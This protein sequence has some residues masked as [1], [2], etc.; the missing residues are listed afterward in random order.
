VERAEE[1]ATPSGADA[2]YVDPLPRS[3]RGRGWRR[4]IA[5][6]RRTTGVGDQRPAQAGGG[7][8]AEVWESV[9]ALPGRLDGASLPNGVVELLV[10]ER[11]TTRRQLLDINDRCVTAIE[12]GSAV[13]WAIVSGSPAAWAAALGPLAETGGLQ[14]TGDEPLARRLLAAA[15][16]SPR[17]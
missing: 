1:A 11:E 16:E 10:E 7:P 3:T 4:W 13:P 17:G 2:S 6:A 8:A 12:P 14:L 15:C 9:Q 5:G